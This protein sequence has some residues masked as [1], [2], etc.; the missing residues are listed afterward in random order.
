MSGDLQPAEYPSGASFVGHK[1]TLVTGVPRSTPLAVIYWPTGTMTD[2]SPTVANTPAAAPQQKQAKRKKSKSSRCAPGS[3]LPIRDERGRRRPKPGLDNSD[4]LSDLFS[5]K[6]MGL[7]QLRSIEQE[8]GIKYK[9]GKFSNSEAKIVNDQVQRFLQ[10]QGLTFDQFRE[11]FL[12]KRGH[13]RLSDFF[14]QIARLLGGRPV[15]HVYHF[16]RRQYH[17][18]NWQ[19]QWTEEEDTT[20]RQLFAKYGPQWEKIG[21]EL[22]RFN[23]NCKDRYR[24]IR[25]SFNKG[26]WTADE[27]ERLKQAIVDLRRDRPQCHSIGQWVADQVKTRS[28]MQCIQKWTS[29]IELLVKRPG[30]Q[31]PFQW[32]DQEDLILLHRIY[33]LV[34]EDESEI[35]WKTLLDETWNH[36]T[37]VCLQRRWKL[38]RRRVYRERMLDMDTIVETLINSLRPLSPDKVPKTDVELIPD[39]E[40]VNILQE[41]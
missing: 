12:N 24:F 26:R 11:Q 20:L 34:V 40:L 15:I 29:S 14:V 5:S 16:L 1:M 18:N 4:H 6:W 2:T 32:T 41:A 17:P 39:A 30:E 38:L 36:W 19:G 9:R 21:Q 37:P 23:V 31:R 7:S 33:D 8:S 13:G 3:I 22:G 27:V 10:Q 25:A 28:W 35:D